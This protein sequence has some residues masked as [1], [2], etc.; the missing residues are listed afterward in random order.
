MK[1]HLPYILF[2]A[3][4]TLAS[5]SNH[6][7]NSF[8]FDDY[9]TIINNPSVTTLTGIPGFFTDPTT[10]TGVANR[11]GFRP[12][13]L[14]TFAIDYW[15]AG[16]YTPRVFH[17]TSFCYFLLLVFLLYLF[18][19][20]EFPGEDQLR[21][22][23]A[24]A[25]TALFALH[26]VVADCVN[27]IVQRGEILAGIG[28]LLGLIL[29]RDSL[30]A[31]RY[32]LY[33]IP[34]ILGCLSKEVAYVFPLLL[35]L[36]CVRGALSTQPFPHA[37]WKGIKQALPSLVVLGSLAFFFVYLRIPKATLDTVV[38]GGISPLKYFATQ[39][40]IIP[41]YIRLFFL[42]IDLSG[43]TDWKTVASFTDP[44][45]YLGAICCLLLV[46]AAFS[47]LSHQSTAIIGF[48]LVWFFICLA[49]TSSFSP[50]TEVRNNH[51][52]FLPYLGLSPAIWQGMILTIRSNLT[53]QI[54]ILPLALLSFGY[55]TFNRNLAWQTNETFW[56]DVTEKSPRNG[57]GQMNYGLSL[58][59]KGDYESARLHFEEARRLTPTY[60]LVYINLGIVETSLGRDSQGE[61]YFKRAQQ[62]APFSESSY[63]FYARWLAKV[64]RAKEAILHLEKALSLNK[65]YRDAASLLIRLYIENNQGSSAQ[66]LC[67]ELDQ[68]LHRDTRCTDLDALKKELVES[69][70]ED[71]LNSLI[72]MTL[73]LYQRKQYRECLTTATNG[74]LHFSQSA[75]LLNNAAVCALELGDLE[76]AESFAR[77]AITLSP[78]F[79]LAANNLTE[80]L[81]RKNNL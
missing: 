81:R 48:G 68:S 50:L 56:Q 15:L 67:G 41:D 26:P 7:D 61:A 75:S 65:R 49:P 2:L 44:N 37:L 36:L 70:R 8:Q 63:F 11:A 79:T 27:Y 28:I 52:L 62:L 32:L 46:V 30:T 14:T 47:L 69:R 25:A 66:K 34:P 22:R 38:T 9:P 3:L 20:K 29:Y 10:T 53:V 77:R 33:T 35:G 6:F 78:N 39:L 4:I 43:D 64:G 54:L 40:Y 17:I 13:L 51:R 55:A 5:Y 76:Q 21:D 72:R 58:M 23:S 19:R 59:A 18:L 71:E 16:D 1:L 73:A 24:F 74:L 12:I 57:R 45:I 60:P 42:P 31:R 80:V